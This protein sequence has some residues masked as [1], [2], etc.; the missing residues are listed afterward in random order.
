ML[1][2]HD[3]S[4]TPP[5]VCVQWEAGPTSWEPRRTIV[6]DAPQVVRSYIASLPASQRPAVQAQVEKLKK[7]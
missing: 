1:V 7:K 4:A 2:D 6:Q 5:T 3:L